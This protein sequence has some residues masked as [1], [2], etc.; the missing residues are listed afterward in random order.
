MYVTPAE[1]GIRIIEIKIILPNRQMTNY[2][3][4]LV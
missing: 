1:P 2:L 4:N 3:L